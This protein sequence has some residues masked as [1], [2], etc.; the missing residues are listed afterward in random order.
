MNLTVSHK[1]SLIIIVIL[2][3]FSAVVAGSPQANADHS[4]REIERFCEVDRDGDEG[5]LDCR[6]RVSDR[7]SLERK[8]SV[9]FDGD[10]GEFNCSG[11]H[12]RDIER[13]CEVD[14][15]GDIDC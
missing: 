7:R 13:R 1:N 8:C 9:E 12:Y 5:E 4:L 3:I 6:S 14:E 11:S 10:E 2:F 15:D